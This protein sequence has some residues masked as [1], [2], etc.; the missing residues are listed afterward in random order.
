MS[1]SILA[2][3][4]FAP[5][6]GTTGTTAMFKD[7]S[8]FVA[9][10]KS[11]SVLRGKQNIADPSSDTTSVGDISSAFSSPDAA[12]VSLGDGG[13]VTLSFDGLIYN[14]P[15]PDFAIFENAFSSTFLELAFVEVS[16]DGINFFRFPAESLTD[17]SSQVGS[18]G[19]LDPTN[20]YNLAGKYQANYGTPF[21]LEEMK[22][23]QG[24]DIDAISHIKVIDVVGSINSS[25]SQRDSKG[26]KINDPYPTA[27]ASGGFDLDAVGVVYIKGVGLEESIIEE[28]PVFPNPSSDRINFPQ[29]WQNAHYQLYSIDGK[30]IK[31]SLLDNQSIDVSFLTQGIYQIQL[32][33]GDKWGI[34]KLIVP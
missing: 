33:L 23:I 7:S 28:V 10:A 20:I 27:F 32:S 2:Q 4:H 22:N 15:G 16:S 19:A 30:K 29:K 12:I 14:G 13:E 5:G 17:T 6:A 25:Y 24:L 21:D 31:E 34:T 1:L 9:W 8:A 18:F 3:G 11:G 26:R